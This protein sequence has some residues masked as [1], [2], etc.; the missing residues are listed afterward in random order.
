M[1]SLYGF[2]GLEKIESLSVKGVDDIEVSY[3][4]AV[5]LLARCK[6]RIYTYQVVFR[7]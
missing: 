3:S 7:G 1:A 4:D 6:A 5:E 2:I